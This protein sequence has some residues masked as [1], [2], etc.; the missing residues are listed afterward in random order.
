M[1][2]RG[3]T[4]IYILYYLPAYIIKKVQGQD[5]IH[6]LISLFVYIEVRNPASDHKYTKRGGTLI[7][8]YPKRL[9]TGLTVHWKDIGKCLPS[10]LKQQY[11]QG[12]SLIFETR[13]WWESECDMSI[14]HIF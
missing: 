3:Y 10:E 14:I 6:E 1:H 2:F 5:V 12:L 11:A 9:A 13:R 7:C 4:Y 8:D